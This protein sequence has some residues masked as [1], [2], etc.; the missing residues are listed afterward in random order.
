[1]RRRSAW[2]GIG[3]LLILT[4]T[5]ASA[6]DAPRDV[7]GRWTGQCYNCPVRSFILVLRQ[8]G[9]QL[10][11]MLQAIGRSGL[12]EKEMP[13][14]TGKIS[15]RSVSFRVIGADG[16]ALD[17]SLTLSRDGQTLEGQGR[18]RASFGLSFS[19]AGS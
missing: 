2:V 12:G 10:T 5:G 16:M 8:D 6:Q 17:S 4:I 15:G 13:L 14:V 7:T 3:F 11:G 1:M 18:H 9:E 19:R